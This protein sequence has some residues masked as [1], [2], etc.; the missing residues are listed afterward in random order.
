MSLPRIF[1]TSIFRLTLLYAGL[2][3]LSVL[4][5][6][7]AIF[8]FGSGY[9]E[10]QIDQTVTNE[11][12]R[13]QSRAAFGDLDHYREVVESYVQRA[14]SGVFYLLENNAGEV[15]VGNMH[16]IKPIVGIRSFFLEV[17][18]ERHPGEV[19]GI[20]GRGIRVADG[21]YL[22]V[23]LDNFE[24]IKM[25][26]MIASFFL[27]GLA[28][29]ISLAIMGG[30]LMSQSLLHSVEG[31]SQASREIVAG[32][33]NRRI[34]VRGVDD[35]FDHLASSLNT[36]LD[37]ITE[38]M[39]GLQQVSSDIAHDLR[40]PLTRLRQ[41]LELA[42]HRE[43]SVEKLHEALDRSIDDVD[44]ILDTFTAL[45]RIAQIEAH[46]KAVGF[47]NVDL[48]DLLR[49]MGDIYQSVA[50]ER[51]QQLGV[52]IPDGL[53]VLGDREL[54]P[55]LFSNLTENAIRH[56]P[57][58]AKIRIEARQVVDGIVVSV[59]D[60]GPGIP[61][62]FRNKV[63]RRFFQ[64]DGSRNNDGTGLGLSL[65][66]AIAGLHNASIELLDNHP[67]LRVKLKFPQL[68]QSDTA[69]RVI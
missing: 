20:R 21:G 23:G 19:L 27:W 53:R 37:R 34:P 25:R 56:C 58:G 3:S 11:L 32:D 55:Q 6:F 46:T 43:N 12:G 44:A 18:S 16:A 42:R 22:Y 41:R 15:L 64:L 17:P 66:A 33:L 29:T 26:E 2:F 57:A 54:L 5:L 1:R 51:G 65:V 9:V 61:P 31:I 10:S 68:E 69:D 14:P 28:A 50:E 40:T 59:S 13:I 67:G 30:F 47:S 39:Q 8:W 60:N 7:V 48:S 24:L 35:E 52:F 62:E 63:F 49:E 38:L 36:M 4:I 45:L